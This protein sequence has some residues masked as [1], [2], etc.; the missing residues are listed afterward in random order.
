MPYHCKSSGDWFKGFLTLVLWDFTKHSLLLILIFVTT[1][2][3]AWIEPSVVTW[4]SGGYKC[5][6]AFIQEAA[7]SPTARLTG[8][9]AAWGGVL[10]SGAT[11]PAAPGVI[12]ALSCITVGLNMLFA[13]AVSGKSLRT[14]P[15]K[16]NKIV[17]QQRS[18]KNWH[19]SPWGHLTWCK[20]FMLFILTNFVGTLRNTL[21]L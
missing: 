17:F 16:K 4:K 2:T 7:L 9:P 8:L 5:I 10:G 19:W 6:D 13:R 21:S 1:A 15:G 11:A 20:K 18:E 14:L 12:K 3:V